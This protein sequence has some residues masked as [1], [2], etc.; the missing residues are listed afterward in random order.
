MASR[1]SVAWDFVVVVGGAAALVFLVSFTW[2]TDQVAGPPPPAPILSRRPA[3]RGPPEL[4]PPPAPLLDLPE[5]SFVT[6]TECGAEKLLFVIL[7]ISHPGN[8]ALR[9]THRTQVSWEALAA[10]GARRVFILA[11]A[12]GVGQPEFPAVERDRVLRESGLH[13]DLVVADFHEHYRNLTYKHVLAL[14]WAAAFCPSAAFLLKMDDDIMVDVWALAELLQVGLSPDPQ[15]SIQTRLGSVGR[16]LV[17][18]EVWAAGMVQRGLRPQRE[19]GKWR[20]TQAEYAGHVYPD[21]LSG[22]AYLAT[23]PAAAAILQAVAT[24]P[25]FWIDDVHVTGTAAALA[26]VPRYSLGPHYSLMSGPAACCL[27]QPT[28]QS[29]SP[30]SSLIPLCDLL[31][32]PS[33]KNVTLM[34]AWLTAARRCHLEDICPVTSPAA[35]RATFLRQGVGTV[36][37]LS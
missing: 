5:V 4:F 26:G 1:R 33:G 11:D 22:W 36:I 21:F 24:L 10:I 12:S 23:Q 3:P 35:C 17:R 30:D 2:E 19:G 16:P 29:S 8:V 15:G 14:S 18:S 31:V 7:V 32:A 13:K 34:A 28:W 27:Q 9:D 6:N 25:P 37:R 20:V